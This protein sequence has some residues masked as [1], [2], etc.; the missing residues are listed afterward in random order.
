L[1]FLEFCL[2][3]RRVLFSLCHSVLCFIYR[4]T[5]FLLQSA[6]FCWFTAC[7]Q[8]FLCFGIRRHECSLNRNRSG[9]ISRISRSCQ[10]LGL[11]SSPE[12]NIAANANANASGEPKS[13]RT[14]RAYQWHLTRKVPM[15][16]ICSTKSGCP[17][18]NIKI[19][20]TTKIYVF[21]KFKR[22]NEMKIKISF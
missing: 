6:E 22:L 12:P 18:Q 13:P 5:N 9:R 21:L 15:T 20:N 3:R 8:F 17:F 16:S 2:R 10:A 7:S 19:G 14:R 4:T 11:S 1:Q